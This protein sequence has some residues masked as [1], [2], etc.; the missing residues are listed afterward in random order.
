MPEEEDEE[1]YQRRNEAA[2][3]IQ[4][5]YKG[6]RVR[7]DMAEKKITEMEQLN[8]PDVEE[9][10]MDSGGEQDSARLHTS[11]LEHGHS[12]EN[13]S[14]RTDKDESKKCL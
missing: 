13:L 10:A 3:M 12:E 6:Y 14:H 7:R 8:D 9:A 1:E 4:K 5:H 2:I 11:F